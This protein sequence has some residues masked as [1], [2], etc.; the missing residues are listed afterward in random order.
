MAVS[1]G[2]G[3]TILAVEFPTCWSGFVGLGPNGPHA[4]STCVA[5]HLTDDLRPAELRVSMTLLISPVHLANLRLLYAFD[6][7]KKH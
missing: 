7:L 5:T 4:L 6:R 1:F 2:S 3:G